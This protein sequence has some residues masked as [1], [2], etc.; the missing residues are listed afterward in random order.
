MFA[1]EFTLAIQYD[2]YPVKD[3][4]DRKGTQSANDYLADT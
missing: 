3:D 1:S 4:G 2:E